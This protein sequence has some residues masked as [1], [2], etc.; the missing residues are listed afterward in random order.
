M[1]DFTFSV[2]SP[3]LIERMYW[4]AFYLNHLSQI[5]QYEYTN[6]SFNQ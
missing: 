1:N 5:L 3:L 4:L 6:G 2:S